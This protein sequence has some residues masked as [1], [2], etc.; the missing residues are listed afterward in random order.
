MEVNG[1]V[2][3]RKGKT[4]KT[5]TCSEKGEWGQSGGGV[6]LLRTAAWVSTGQWEKKEPCEVWVAILNISITDWVARQMG[7]DP[8]FKALL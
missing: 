3:M 2:K 1:K 7:F 6:K 5:K 4:A 8:D